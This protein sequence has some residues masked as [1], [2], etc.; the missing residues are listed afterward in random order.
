M[1]QH[2]ARAGVT[3]LQIISNVGFIRILRICGMMVGGGTLEVGGGTYSLEIGNGS[4]HPRHHHFP[5]NNHIV[6]YLVDSG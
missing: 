3:F 1:S 2:Q 6:S 4:M 5:A